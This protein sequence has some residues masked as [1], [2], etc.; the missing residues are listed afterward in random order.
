MLSRLLGDHFVRYYLIAT[1]LSTFIVF[2]IS[3]PVMFCC[4][5][6]ISTA[7]LATRC[8]TFRGLLQRF[9]REHFVNNYLI[10]TKLGTFIVFKIS[11]L[12]ISLKVVYLYCQSC[13][14]QRLLR[15]FL[16]DY[17]LK[18]LPDCYRTWHVYSFQDSLSSHVLETSVS[19]PLVL[20]HD[21]KLSEGF[22][23]G[24]FARISLI[25][26]R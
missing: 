12:E 23:D 26:T 7:G 18:K 4:K 24:F 14:K 1:Q 3:F 6:C 25:S 22:F 8:Q 16:H 19:L 13:Y 11:F 10:V 20:L 9:L 21:V 17:L 15:G 5:C 2:R